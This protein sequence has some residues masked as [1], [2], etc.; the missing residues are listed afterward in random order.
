MVALFRIGHRS[1]RKKRAAQESALAAVVLQQGEVYMK[2]HAGL[3]GK[4]ALLK[5]LMDLF[6]FGEH[7]DPFSPRLRI[8]Q[9]IKPKRQGLAQQA[10]QP[11][12]K[13]A[14][15][16]DDPDAAG[17]KRVGI[18]QH[19]VQFRQRAAAPADLDPAQFTFYASGKGHG[20]SLPSFVWFNSSKAGFRAPEGCRRSSK[21][22]AARLRSAAA[23]P[24]L[25]RRRN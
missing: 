24:P 22:S 19:A 1:P 20:A 16:R 12:A 9:N 8:R 11:L 2:R 18:Q 4:A 7:I 15:L 3:G 5:D 14:A 17:R 6:R 25:S 13:I 23:H 21:L 10:H